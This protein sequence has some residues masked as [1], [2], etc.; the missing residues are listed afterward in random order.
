M[1]FIFIDFCYKL[2]KKSQ[3]TLYSSLSFCRP[4]IVMFCPGAPEPWFLLNY[5]LTMLTIKASMV[6]LQCIIFSETCSG[7]NAEAAEN[8]HICHFVALS[9]TPELHK[10][11][12]KLSQ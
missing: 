1:T 7:K 10:Q 2:L 3:G 12:A 9:S 6:H 11:H 5:Q 8:G 4:T